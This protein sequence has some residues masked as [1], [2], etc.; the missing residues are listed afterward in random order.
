MRLRRLAVATAAL[1]SA[2]GALAFTGVLADAVTAGPP[3][4]D[5]TQVVQYAAV[6][7]EVTAPTPAAS[8]SVDAGWLDRTSAAASIGSRALQAYAEASLRVDREQPTCHLGWLTLAAIGAVESAH[9]THGG[10][11]LAA[12]GRPTV[13]IEGPALDGSDGTAA[14]EAAGSWDRAAGPMQFITSTWQQWGADGDGDGVAD[15]QDIDDAALAAG[16]Y[17]C[18]SGADLRTGAGWSRAVF[19]YNH[20]DEYVATVLSVADTYAGRLGR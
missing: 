4:V 14:I 9:G 12:D 10:A 19:S 13:G 7:Q 6:A 8:S 2:G 16:R 3:H 18:A 1:A 20:S 17:L 5:D 15:P 11:V